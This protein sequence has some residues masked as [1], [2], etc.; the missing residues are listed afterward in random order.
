MFQ[1]FVVES[2]KVHTLLWRKSVGREGERERERD[3]EKERERNTPLYLLG[4]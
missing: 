4:K 3:T 1:A 2:F